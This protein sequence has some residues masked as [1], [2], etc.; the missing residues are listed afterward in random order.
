MRHPASVLTLAALVGLLACRPANL[1]PGAPDTRDTRAV[2]GFLEAY[3]RRDLDGMMRFLTEDAVFRGSDRNLAKPDLRAFF[4]ATFRRHPDLR[5]EVGAL[6]V[7]QGAVH[8]RVTVRTD[9]IWTDTWIFELKDHRIRAYALA[10]GKRMINSQLRNS[11][12]FIER[13]AS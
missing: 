3:S 6:Q 12:A 1:A 2:L 9:A 7:V 11:A 4:Q 13:N 10:S 5:V 8:V